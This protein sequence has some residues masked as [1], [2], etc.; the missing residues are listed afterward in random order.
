MQEARQAAGEH[1]PRKTRSAAS[2]EEKGT[3]YFLEK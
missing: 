3:V 1:P 2:D